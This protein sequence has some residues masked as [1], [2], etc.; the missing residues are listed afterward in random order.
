VYQ[1]GK[2]ERVHRGMK[3]GYESNFLSVQSAVRETLV[4]Q[5]QAEIAAFWALSAQVREDRGS[6]VCDRVSRWRVVLE[7]R[8]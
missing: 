5:P 6:S 2:R 7:G 4:P 1:V 8:V 3:E